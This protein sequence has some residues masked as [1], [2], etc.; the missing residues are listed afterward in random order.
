MTSTTW[1]QLLRVCEVNLPSLQPVA[2]TDVFSSESSTSGREVEILFREV[3]PIGL[4]VAF[5]EASGLMKVRKVV[6]RGQAEAW[7]MA[8]NMAPI[9]IVDAAVVAVNGYKVAQGQAGGQQC[10]EWMGNKRRP[11][12]LALQLKPGA[13]ALAK[14][15]ESKVITEPMKVNLGPPTDG[16]AR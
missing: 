1:P 14:A 3:K 9:C 11:L 6:E 5:D 16:G 8:R 4:A 7:C 10:I 15:R 2:P 13:M 12:A